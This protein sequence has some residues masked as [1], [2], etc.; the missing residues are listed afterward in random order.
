[1]F[2]QNFRKWYSTRPTLT[3]LSFITQWLSWMNPL[4]VFQEKKCTRLYSV[5]RLS[6]FWFF[7]VTW[8]ISRL[9]NYWQEFHASWR[10]LSCTVCVK[11]KVIHF[12]RPIVLKSID[13][14]ICMW[15]IS[16]GQLILFPLVPF[17]HRVCHAWPI[18]LPLKMTMSV[19]IF[20]KFCELDKSIIA[21]QRIVLLQRLSHLMSVDHFFSGKLNNKVLAT[22]PCDLEDHLCTFDMIYWMFG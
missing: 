10:V 11:I 6:H 12:Q 8:P 16:K 9:T 20:C 15:H 13:L 4:H 3:D 22:F 1:M 7:L 17:L 14:N 21:K 2:N 5:I 18:T 19:S